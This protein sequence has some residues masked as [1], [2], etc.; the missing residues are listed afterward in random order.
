MRDIKFRAWYMKCMWR[1][2]Q[3]TWHDD[4]TV[5]GAKL[6]NDGERGLS[7]YMEWCRHHP[8]V[9]PEFMQYTGLIDKEGREVC[10][11]DIIESDIHEPARMEIK[12]LEGAFCATHPKIDLYPLDICHFYPSTGCMFKVIGNVHENPE[13][14]GD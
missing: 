12:F 2:S 13:I 7:G 6:R 1:V 3:L 5:L 11:G 9:K 4:E 10:E 14:L 8:Y